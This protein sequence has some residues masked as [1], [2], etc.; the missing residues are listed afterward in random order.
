MVADI[1]LVCV[2][3]N[4]HHAPIGIR[5]QIAF[6]AD[7]L[8]TAL[9][10]VLAYDDIQE[11]AIV[12]TCNRVELYAKGPHRSLESF[13]HR[14]HDLPDLSLSPHLYRFQGIQAVA[15]LFRVTT[16]LDSLIVGE[17]QILGQVKDAY[18]RAQKAGTVGPL[19][20][21]VFSRAFLTAKRVRNE[22]AIGQNAVTISYAAATLAQKVFADLFGLRALLVGAG[23]MAELAAK[24][25]THKG[26][27]VSV[28][29]RSHASFS[30]HTHKLNELE[31]LLSQNDVVLTSTN[32]QHHLIDMA[33]MRKIMRLRR[34]KPILLID[35]AVPRNIDAA[36][37]GL[38]GVYLYNIDDL[39]QVVTQNLVQRQIEARVAEQII[40]EEIANFKQKEQEKY[41]GPLIAE[42]KQTAHAIADA[43]L[44]QTL[45]QLE[46]DD[47]DRK[48]I[49]TMTHNIVNKILHGPIIDLKS[50]H[51]HPQNTFS[52]G[53]GS[54]DGG[55]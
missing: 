45:S 27:I 6:S 2:G 7:K 28:A 20:T 40:D 21:R 14:Y 8:S 52:F 35:I 31:K 1:E 50:F 32:A 18:T 44:L 42:L 4:H 51:Q 43:Q 10:S 34:Y 26:M 3:L 48:K 16:S 11:A 54:V 24:H 15:Q 33:L 13:L 47:A 19:L 36:I 39:S 30:Q 9:K 29:N 41:A 23:E 5:E 37:G 22:T 53:G 25:F 46:L 55:T 17:P 49:E 12:S 38:D